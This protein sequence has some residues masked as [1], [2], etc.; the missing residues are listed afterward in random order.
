MDTASA[1]DKKPSVIRF[2]AHVISVVF[3]PLFITSYVAA[4]LI[5]WHPYAFAGFTDKLKMFRLIMVIFNTTFIP[6]FAVFLMWRL[7]L[8]ESMFL[9]TTK[10][11]IIPY[12]AAMTCFFWAWYVTYRQNDS[13]EYFVHFM[14]GSFLAVCLTFL[15]NIYLKV[16]MHTTA[17]GGAVVFFL[18]QSFSEPDATGLYFAIA[19][20]IAGLVGTARLI[21]SDHRP[22]EIYVGYVAG[23]ACQL[24]AIYF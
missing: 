21:V 15:L 5:Y 22:A 3:H 16:S 6:L 1:P 7:G 20:I 12:V 13:P 23:A 10:E 4:F 19:T 8:I 17:M 14:L 11:R 2:L 9:R 24:I 18:M